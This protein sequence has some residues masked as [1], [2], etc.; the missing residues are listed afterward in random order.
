M[1]S[2]TVLNASQLDILPVVRKDGRLFFLNKDASIALRDDRHR[3]SAYSISYGAVWDGLSVPWA[4]RWFLPNYDRSNNLYNWA[5]LLHDALY[6]SELLPKDTADDVFRSIL[7]DS[8][9]SRFRG[10]SA[11]FWMSKFSGGHYGQAHDSHG[12][13]FHIKPM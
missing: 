5:G 12:I 9:V 1:A 11:E 2:Y 10:S 4:L 3:L 8:G 13:R 6:G 7:R